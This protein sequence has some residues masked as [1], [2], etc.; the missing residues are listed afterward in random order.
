MTFSHVAYTLK[1]IVPCQ[2]ARKI[3]FSSLIEGGF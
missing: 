1:S 2:M 3:Q